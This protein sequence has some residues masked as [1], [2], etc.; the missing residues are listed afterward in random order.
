M[1]RHI[2]EMPLDFCN[3]VF[4]EI[5]SRHECRQTHLEF[6]VTGMWNEKKIDISTVNLKQLILEKHITSA[7]LLQH[8][9]ELG[10]PLDN[11][12]IKMSMNCLQYNQ[13]Q[14]FKVI[15]VHPNHV[16]EL[17]ICALKIDGYCRALSLTR[18]F[19]RTLLE[20]VDLAS[21]MKT[22]IVNY[23]K[24]IEALLD[25]GVNPNRSG[26]G[27]TPIAM[28]MDR[29]TNW[30][31][32][33]ELVCLLLDKGE[34]CSHL[35][36]K[37]CT[38]PLHVATEVALKSGKNFERI[39]R[40]PIIRRFCPLIMTGTYIVLHR[41]YKLTIQ[42]FQAPHPTHPSPHKNSKILDPTTG[43]INFKS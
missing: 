30:S 34:H 8:F 40:Y 19:T 26:D 11:D 31:K 39:Y 33:I 25:G 22:D 7:S 13:L 18:Q 15:A 42:P 12:D 3:K 9:L 1:V 17:L 21:L 6:L 29:F 28:V 32:K 20:K 2:R 41:F 5:L 35:S 37:S 14:L 23:P 43:W 38:P 10:L 27:T 36:S 16:E 24:L 4:I